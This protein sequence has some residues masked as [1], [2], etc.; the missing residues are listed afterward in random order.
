MESKDNMEFKVACIDVYA[1]IECERFDE[2]DRPYELVDDD[3]RFDNL[4]P[5]IEDNTVVYRTPEE[6]KDILNACWTNILYDN[7]W[8]DDVEI[9]FFPSVER[10]EV[11]GDTM[12]I[13]IK[14][15]PNEVIEDRTEMIFILKNE[16]MD[17]DDY[18]SHIDRITRIVREIGEEKVP[19]LTHLTNK[20]S[21]DEFKRN[22]DELESEIIGFLLDEIAVLDKAMNLYA[23]R[24]NI[25]KERMISL[26]AE[27]IFISPASI[28]YFVNEIFDIYSTSLIGPKQSLSDY[29]GERLLG[30]WQEAFN[31]RAWSVQDFLSQYSYILPPSQKIAVQD[32]LIAFE[33]INTPC[34]LITDKLEKHLV[35]DIKTVHSL[36]RST[37]TSPITRK[38]ITGVQIMNNKMIRIFN[39]E[40]TEIQQGEMKV[41]ELH[42]KLR[43]IQKEIADSTPEG[44]EAKHALKDAKKRAR[45]SL[46][47]EYRQLKNERRRVKRLLKK[48]PNNQEI[49][50]RRL[51]ELSRARYALTER[52]YNNPIVIAAKDRLQQARDKAIQ[53]IRKQ[54]R[55]RKQIQLKEKY[56][57]YK[58]QRRKLHGVSILRF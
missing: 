57:K 34:R 54:R 38:Y 1:R 47:E 24:K 39:R 3:F 40:H 9:S 6:L 58:R 52:A 27:S 10:C 44:L 30:Q 46:K 25:T 37:G 21:E 17:Y 51:K 22:R 55:T 4:A 49:L 8:D 16:T 29:L 42:E 7:A 45:D 26:I 33:E 18:C 2:Y 56:L 28:E 53:D 5:I 48:N 11:D 19:Q 31:G 41:R 50:R 35:Y 14:Y 43:T 36:L 15:T 32:D 20:K 12:K 13:Y 23:L